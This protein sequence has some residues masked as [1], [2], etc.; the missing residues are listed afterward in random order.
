MKKCYDLSSIS[1][2]IM[3]CSRRNTPI[4]AA[5][6]YI[7]NQV[8]AVHARRR[9][10]GATVQ[11]PPPTQPALPQST[12]VQIGRYYGGSLGVSMIMCLFNY[13]SWLNGTLSRFRCL[14]T[15][16]IFA[17]LAN[18]DFAYTKAPGSMKSLVTSLSLLS[19]SRGSA[20]GF[21]LSPTTTYGKVTV[22]FIVLSGPM[23]LTAAVFCTLFSRY[24]NKEET[25]NEL[26]REPETGVGSRSRGTTYYSVLSL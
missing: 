23:A 15:S 8:A 6:S 14:S 19:C 21:A 7:S 26:E 5:I 16:E 12:R 4:S 24:N 11:P 22:E 2:S 1:L 10:L 17:F 3:S 25:M 20:V 13:S 18:L 9:L